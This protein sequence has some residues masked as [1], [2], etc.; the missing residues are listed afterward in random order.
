MARAAAELA[1]KHHLASVGRRPAFTIVEALV[2]VSIVGVLIAIAAPAARGVA[3]ASKRTVCLAN[4]R[5]LHLATSMYTQDRRGMLPHATSPVWVNLGFVAP[6][7]Q[8]ER[9]VRVPIVPID[10]DGDFDQPSA[11]YLCPAD[12][13]VGPVSG[14]SYGYIPSEF[15]VIEGWQEVSMR[16]ALNPRLLLFIDRGSRHPGERRP[17]DWGEPG[18]GRNAVSAGGQLGWSFELLEVAV[19]R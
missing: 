3:D 9:Y 18:V 4:L 7:D 19:R 6:L 15:I 12:R 10:A 14:F 13:D 1:M 11:P 8:L 5:T 17:P 16:Y 2:A